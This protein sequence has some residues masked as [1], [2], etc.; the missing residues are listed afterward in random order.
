MSNNIPNT[1]DNL[2]TLLESTRDDYTKFYDSGNASA[3]TRVRKVMQEVKTLA[4]ET[5]LHVQ[6]TKNNNT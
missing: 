1:L 4:Q 5:R 3:G 6:E 2:I